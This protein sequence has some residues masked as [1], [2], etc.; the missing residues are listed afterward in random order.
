MGV[1]VSLLMK[2]TE[3]SLTHCETLSR[4]IVSR[5]KFEN[6]HPIFEYLI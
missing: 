6:S 2:T 5:Y 1:I 4:E 3:P